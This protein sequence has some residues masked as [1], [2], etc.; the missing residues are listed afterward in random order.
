MSRNP[1]RAPELRLPKTRQSGLG[2]A[3]TSLAF[4][5]LLML[6]VAWT[7]ERVSD[8]EYR[9]AGRV[10]SKGEGGGGGGAA[11]R[12]VELPPYVPSSS[13]D[14]PERERRTAREL[15]IPKPELREIRTDSRDITIVRPTGRV[16]MAEV[17]GRGLG[18][19]GG[20]G[21][22]TGSGGGIGS[23]R[24]TGEGGG[25]GSGTGGDGGSGFGP[26]S[27]QMLLPPE[28][29]ASVKG[30]EFKVRFWI[31][32]RGRVTRIEVEP[33]IP[34][35]GY[36]REFHERMRQFRFYP[37]RDSEDN[38]IASFYDAWIIP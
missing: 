26:Q 17:V 14:T 8:S 18:S 12:Y 2:G 16:A 31:N 1:P 37:A 23:G 22:G 19:G 36:R 33:R 4:H 13:S 10:G 24:G 27:R 7:G 28:A 5:G 20:P 29:P 3:F 38:P 15:S 11:V 6:L 21:A 9:A 30:R 34:D 25:I 32:E 35:A